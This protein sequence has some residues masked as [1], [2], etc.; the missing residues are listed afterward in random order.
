MGS[1]GDGGGGSGCRVRFSG[2]IVV[3]VVVGGGDSG[4]RDELHVTPGERRIRPPS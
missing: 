1:S 2:E 4:R 3:V